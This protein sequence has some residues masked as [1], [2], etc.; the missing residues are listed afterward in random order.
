MYIPSEITNASVWTICLSI[1]GDAF[2]VIIVL[3]PLYAI[4]IHYMKKL[5]WGKY[6]KQYNKEN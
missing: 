4:T 1:I 6:S 5:G 3:S 2:T